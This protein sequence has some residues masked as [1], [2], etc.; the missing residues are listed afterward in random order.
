MPIPFRT[1]RDEDSLGLAGYLRL[2]TEEKGRGIR[3]AL[4]LVNARGEPVDFAF[5]RIDVSVSF[6]WR[7]G[8]A[9]RTAVVSLVAALFQACPKVP[10]LLLALSAEVH[11]LLF[12][13]DLVLEVPICRVA[14]G[15]DAAPAISEASESLS[16]A[17]HLFWVGQPPEEGSPARRLLDALQARHIITEPFQRAALGIE[18]AFRE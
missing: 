17:I 3:G 11:P 16:T 8:D 15:G 9:K 18:E 5:S 7:T 10:S 14:D 13:E 12:T 6:L 1:L 2:I 4:F